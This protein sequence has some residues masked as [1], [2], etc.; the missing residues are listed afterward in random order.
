VTGKIVPVKART[1][2]RKIGYDCLNIC[3]YLKLVK[4]C[5]K[6]LNFRTNRK[7]VI[8]LKFCTDYGTQYHVN[9]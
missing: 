4:V 3:R 9:H 7:V 6:K 1:I 5:E 2:E 8:T